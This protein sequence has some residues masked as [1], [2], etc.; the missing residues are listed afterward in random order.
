MVSVMERYLD[1]P[2]S[3]GLAL[4]RMRGVIP[5]IEIARYKYRSGLGGLVEQADWFPHPLR[6]VAV[7][8]E[9]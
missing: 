3:V 1:R 6:G 4:H 2:A 9:A 8:R 5:V 7:C